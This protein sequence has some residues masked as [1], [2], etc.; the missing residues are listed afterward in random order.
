MKKQNNQLFFFAICTTL[1][2][3]S[4]LPSCKK[5]EK[6]LFTQLSAKETGINFKNALKYDRNFNI[7]KYRNFYNGGG[8]AT[9]DLN[10]DGLLDVYM[11]ANMDK[12][13]LYLN[14]GGFRFEDVTDAAGVGG[15]RAWSTGV[16]MADVNGDGWLDIYVCNSGDIKG[17]NR[18][19]ELFINNKNGTFTEKAKEYGLADEGYSTHAAFFDYDRDG[20]LDCYLLNNSYK[21]I[22]SFNL[23]KN[24]RNVRDSLGGHKLFRNDG[25]KFT[26]VSTQAGIYG[27]VQA[28]GL[29]VTVGDI[30]Q[31]GWADLYVCNDFFEMDYL[32][33][34]QKNGTFKE[35]ATQQINHMS[36]ASM[37]ADLADINNDGYPDLF[38]TEMLPANNQ[39]LK[40][41]T[42]FDSWD[43]YQNYVYNGYYQQFTHNSLQINNQDGTFSEVALASGVGATDWSWGALITDLDNDGKKDLYV[44]NGI[45]Q[46]LTDQDFIQFISDEETKRAVISDSGVDYK[47][48]IDA[49]PVEPLSNF[50]FRNLGGLKFEDMAQKWGLAQPSFSNGSAYADLDNDGDLD[51]IVNNTNM[52][53]FVYRNEANDLLKENHFLKFNLVGEGKNPFAFGTKVTIKQG[54]EIFYQE[55]YPSRGFQSSV[56]PRLN[57]GLGAL[58]A[59]D[60]V[61]IDF[62]NGKRKILTNIKTNQVLTLQQQAATDITPPQYVPT[63]KPIFEEMTPKMALNFR[64]REDTFSDFNIERL[65]FHMNST[66][67][68][69]IAV[70]DVNGDGTDDFYIG[71]ARGQAGKLFLQKNNNFV[72]TQQ[73]GFEKD[74][75]FEDVATIFFDADKDGDLDLFV[76]SGGSRDTLYLDDRIYKNDGKGNFKRDYNALPSGKKAATACARAHDFD[77]DGFLDLFCGMRLTPNRYGQAVSGYLFK[78]DGKGG[79]DNVTPQYAPELKDFGM[80]TDAT[81]ADLDGDKVAELVVV[82]E[83]APISIF[84]KIG[85][86]FENQTVKNGLNGSNGWWN[87]VKTADLDGDGDLDLV[88]GNHGLNSRFKASPNA[89][90][91]MYVG[92]FDQNGMS[93]Q[94]ICTS[95][96]GKSYPCVLRHDLSSQMPS[97]KKKFLHYKDYANQTIQQILTPMQM[98]A[99]QKYEAFTLQSSVAWNDGKGNFT[100]APLPF[101]AQWSTAQA[102]EIADFDGDNV[103]DIFVGGNFFEA[104]P[105]MGRY[106][107]NWGLVL[108]GNANRQFSAIPFRQSQMKIRGAVRDAA[109]VKVGASRQLFV[110][111]NNDNIRIFKLL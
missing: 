94:L 66:E 92:D 86:K 43:R 78:N 22:G 101:E 40:T 111:Q 109:L 83:Y 70:G 104:K 31:D 81:W 64:H 19:N 7:Y 52:E 60:S 95:E 80:I 102:L 103:L 98:K 24:I 42:T 68:P 72:N 82:G 49:I 30:N 73:I 26:D 107:A 61:F 54:N 39:R 20:D 1:T 38:N 89:P 67:G 15:M 5:T 16:T 6:T 53:A 8:V 77:G 45:Y 47:K 75:N 91:S 88:L 11:T 25:E 55:L 3:L 105:E 36:A 27:S 71:G 28:F 18:E 56:D 23:Q 46:D 96:N 90:I 87:V 2:V 34:N 14:R 4:L 41:K 44:A 10:N 51:L 48:L 84:K 99:A 21:A 50:A 65:I 9:G 13:R 74:K 110:V 32:Y 85:Q 17:D 62:P 63:L 106:D 37:G 100:L 69:R 58:A 97:M 29:G 93:E 59:V 35:V 108:R 76:G 79:F 57:F 33:L 12:N